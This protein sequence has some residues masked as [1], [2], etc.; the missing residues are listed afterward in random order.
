MRVKTYHFDPFAALLGVLSVLLMIG[1][2]PLNRKV[3][4]ALFLLS[5]TE[6]KIT[7]EACWEA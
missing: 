3:V 2:L 7:W 1:K 4:G 5:K 6:C